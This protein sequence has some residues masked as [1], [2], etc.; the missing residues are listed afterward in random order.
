MEK[1]CKPEEDVPGVGGHVNVRGERI[2]GQRQTARYADQVP[3][4]RPPCSLGC[5]KLSDKLL[6]LGKVER[7]GGR[8]S[9]DTN[10]TTEMKNI[11]RIQRKLTVGWIGEV[12]QRLQHRQLVQDESILDRSFP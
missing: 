2:D 6:S 3:R 4:P 7:G 1:S 12:V 5:L 10:Q 11:P 9:H 8:D